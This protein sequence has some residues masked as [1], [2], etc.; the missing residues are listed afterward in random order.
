ML[1]DPKVSFSRRLAFD[2]FECGLDVVHLKETT[3]LSRIAA[4]LSETDLNCVA[5]KND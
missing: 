3:F 5:R 4:I 2:F 1:V